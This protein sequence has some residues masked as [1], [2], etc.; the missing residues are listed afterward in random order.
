MYFWKNNSLL[1]LLIS[2]NLRG[3]LKISAVWVGLVRKKTVLRKKTAVFCKFFRAHFCILL[4]K[5][6]TSSF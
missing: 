4:L 5:Q 3:S 6:R 2:F 1:L